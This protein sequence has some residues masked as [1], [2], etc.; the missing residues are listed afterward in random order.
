[1]FALQ[2]WAEPDKIKVKLLLP[3]F[4]GGGGCSAFELTDRQWGYLDM[5]YRCMQDLASNVERMPLPDAAK[6]SVCK[7]LEEGWLWRCPLHRRPNQP[8]NRIINRPVFEEDKQ[9]QQRKWMEEN[10]SAI[11]RGI[12]DGWRRDSGTLEH[13]TVLDYGACMHARP[14]T[15]PC[16]LQACSLKAS[17]V[18]TVQ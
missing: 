8:F 6:A 1:L 14:D 12:D 5:R 13:A 7:Q 2:S 11:A 15:L 3:V 10:W 4:Y 16:S 9:Q 17:P 18:K